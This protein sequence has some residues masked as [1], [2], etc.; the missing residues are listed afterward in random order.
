MDTSSIQQQDVG[1]EDIQP[2]VATGLYSVANRPS[3]VELTPEPSEASDS[4]K[5]RDNQTTR[6]ARAP[7]RATCCQQLCSSNGTFVQPEDIDE[8]LNNIAWSKKPILRHSTVL[9]DQNYSEGAYILR[10]GDLRLRSNVTADRLRAKLKA[11]RDQNKP[12]WVVIGKHQ[13]SL[14]WSLIVYWPCTVFWFSMFGMFAL[15]CAGLVPNLS[16]IGLDTNFDTFAESDS[17][18]SLGYKTALTFITDL[19]AANSRRLTVDEDVPNEDRIALVNISKLVSTWWHSAR[20][21]KSLLSSGFAST[22]ADGIEEEYGLV[23]EDG[24]PGRKLQGIS[25]YKQYLITLIHIPLDGTD[26]NMLSQSNLALMRQIETKM[27]ALSP[28]VKLCSTAQDSYKHHC[29]PGVSM[30]NMAFPSQTVSGQKMNLVLNGLGEKGVSSEAAV[31]IALSNNDITAAVWPTTAYASKNVVLPGTR[32]CYDLSDGC[33][34]WAREG[35]CNITST[36]FMYMQE[37][38]GLTCGLCTKASSEVK[39]TTGSTPVAV[40]TLRSNFGIWGYCCNSGDKPSIPK[41]VKQLTA[42]W[43]ELITSVSMTL[44]AFN[45]DQKANVEAAKV[46]GR[47]PVG[48]RVLY[49]AD[50]VSGYATG[51][52]VASDTKWAICAMVFV[53]LYS[54]LHT[55]SLLLALVGNF[56]VLLSIP[57]SLSVF[58]L[59]SGS[60]TVSLMLALSIFIILG[61]G[62]EMLFVYCDFYK[63]SATMTDD[64]IER[65]SYTVIQAASNTAANAFTNIVSCYS[66][67][68]STLRALREFGFFLGNA[69]LLAW[70]A[71][72][73]AVPPLLVLNEAIQRRAQRCL[74]K[75]EEV[76]EEPAGRRSSIAR[77]SRS[78]RV[79]LANAI[80]PTKKGVSESQ[81]D[82][83]SQKLSFFLGRF[84][85]STVIFFLVIS[86]LQGFFAY[87]E[88][89]LASGSPP[90]FGSDANLEVIKVYT[91]KFLAYQ[92]AK[93]TSGM[94]AASAEQCLNLFDFTCKIFQCT[95]FGPPRGQIGSCECTTHDTP[96]ALPNDGCGT[97]QVYTQVSGRDG[98]Q[99]QHLIWSDFASL[100]RSEF[101][102]AII[103]DQDIGAGPLSE[104]MLLETFNW[105]AGKTYMGQV[106]S[107]PTATVRKKPEGLSCTLHQMCYCGVPRCQG[108]GQ[109]VL[110]NL[111]MN[112][113]VVSTRLLQSSG[114]SKVA[115]DRQADVLIM[116]GLDIVGKNQ[117]LGVA[118]EKPYAFSSTFNLQDPWAQRLMVSLC[119]DFPT[120][121]AVT[122]SIC[123]IDGF[124]SYW[125][126]QGREWPVRS[127][128]DF[129]AEAK[130]FASKEQTSGF[131]TTDFIWFD[132]NNKIQGT[133]AQVY[134]DVA[135]DAGNEQGLNARD[136]WDNHINSFNANAEASIKGVWH[137]S[138]LWETS[139]AQKVIIEST[140]ESLGYSFGF[141]LIGVLV[142]T[143]SL[144][145]SCL[146]VFEVIL[147]ILGLAFFMIV[148]MGWSFGAIEVLSLIIF[149][150]NA[151]D[152]GMLLAN[153]YHCCH[154]EDVEEEEED[155]VDW[156]DASVVAQKGS[157]NGARKSRVTVKIT[158]T[159]IQRDKSTVTK[160]KAILARNRGAERF[161]RTRY[162]LEG[163]GSAIIGSAFTIIGSAGFLLPCTLNVFFKIGAVVCGV[164]AYAAIYT[165]TLLP[166]MLMIMG[167][168]GHD[169]KSV[170]Q[171][172]ARV[173]DQLA[174]REDEEEDDGE[175][176]APEEPDF[177]RY[178]LNMPTK[179]MGQCD[180]E[181]NASRSKVSMSG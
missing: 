180:A 14:P 85:Y 106:I 173:T 37:F 11:C 78:S 28:Y 96:W 112:G 128:Y 150:G 88:L 102:N 23:A 153:R 8:L 83:L 100:I 32:S 139:E 109:A 48:I 132:S 163:L 59:S 179:G 119:T 29:D 177:R 84:K 123:W 19:R 126:R 115:P 120:E 134:I 31:R 90:V 66:N 162:S 125:I 165:L 167:P 12:V 60:A 34:K 111:R 68:T 81:A 15:I 35:A 2:E 3:S 71:L 22:I 97:Y 53:I 6:S 127:T 38:C 103:R 86:G 42:T 157:S 1:L 154:I 55:R 107:A 143:R 166:A 133:Y 122:R 21:L 10:V 69:V 130:A 116:F 113:A 175:G 18:D 79:A 161:E 25:L 87:K 138:K 4:I 181:H 117:L 75:G 65:I 67:L 57:M 36:Y 72:L 58:A 39:S 137:A 33:S 104:S 149:A 169:F 13:N 43:E 142:F 168:C 40:N 124:R 99:P 61:V 105:D 160:N 147:I 170:I 158:D 70:L 151:V 41:G 63:Q 26:Q 30:A 136:R 178:V 46:S 93:I 54:V 108:S 49:T 92:P 91:P 129:N 73:F 16:T 89:T 17:Q 51:E 24:S 131:Q 50:G 64:P 141:T 144:V 172:L 145:I 155:E 80:D 7:A 94:Y 56:L 101:P 52:A 45:A 77:A 62:C 98:L 159:P 121:L 140:L 27:R 176:D 118:T 9:G 114:V 5:V 74:S 171:M 82:F 110:G 152:Y 164:M 135:R 148:V 47:T 95:T 20:S 174:L 146:V 44:D 156:K 76:V